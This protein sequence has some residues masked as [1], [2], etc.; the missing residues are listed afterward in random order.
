MTPDGGRVDNEG[1]VDKVLLFQ[2]LQETLSTSYLK[3]NKIQLHFY[4]PLV[5]MKYWYCVLEGI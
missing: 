2:N 3:N 1:R 4:L 5:L